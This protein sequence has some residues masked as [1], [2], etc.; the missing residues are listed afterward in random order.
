GADPAP[1]AVDVH[2]PTAAERA[3]LVADVLDA[4]PGATGI[5]VT[6]TRETWGD[7][8]NAAAGLMLLRTVLGIHARVTPATLADLDLPADLRLRLD[9]ASSGEAVP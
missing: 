5:A 8:A 6:S 2:A 4:H 3:A 7:A 1:Q 9:A